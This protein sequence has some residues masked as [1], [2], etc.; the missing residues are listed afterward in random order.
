MKLE[1]GDV[2][3]QAEAGRRD[4]GQAVVSFGS[5]AHGPPMLSLFSGILGA[6]SLRLWSCR[7][8]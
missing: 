6:R 8:S 4:V 2:A 3:L 1:I 5:H 7:L